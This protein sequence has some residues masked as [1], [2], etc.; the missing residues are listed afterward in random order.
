MPDMSGKVA[1]VTGAS[2]GIGR[3]TALLLAE[4]GAHVALI[5]RDQE[6]LSALA[7]EIHKEGA[8]RL[9]AQQT[10]PIERRELR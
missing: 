2:S 10:S 7:E 5:A 6:A 9:S 4:R 8:A 3:A 1:L